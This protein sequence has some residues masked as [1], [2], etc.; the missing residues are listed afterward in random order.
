MDP[1]DLQPLLIRS[2]RDAAAGI[3]LFE[4]A[5]AD[6]GPLPPFTPGAHV[7]V[8][9]PDGALRKYSLCGAPHDADRWQIAV[10]REDGGRGGSRSLHEHARAGD[11][12][13]V[14]AP[15]NAFGLVPAPRYLFIAGGIG[16]TPIRS[17]ILDLGDPP[18]APWTLVYLTRDAAATAFLDEFAA[19]PAGGRVIVHHDG[20]DPARAFD[21]WPLLEKPGPGH[22]Y[23]C[24]PRPLMDAVRDMT[25]HWPGGRVHFESF[26]DGAAARPDDRPFAVRLARS[27]RVL[28]VPVGRSLLQVL[29]DA[30]VEVPSSCESGTCGSCRT[31]LLAG[32]ADHRDLVLFPEEHATAIMVCVSRAC[33][34][35]LV[36]D[37]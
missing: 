1:S 4:L 20:G 2:I 32:T 12:I 3:R 18:H 22:V 25:G 10:K 13:A 11:P 30:G 15:A 33:G 6:G 23:C 16:I 35:E 14:S 9:T 28:E 7:T 29:R 36:I 24:G 37:R 21:L 19:P 26:V 17:M 5:R 34:G 31:T 8:R 27:G